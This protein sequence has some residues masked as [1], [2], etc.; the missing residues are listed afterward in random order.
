MNEFRG[1]PAASRKNKK[2]TQTGPLARIKQ[3]TTHPQPA[4]VTFPIGVAQNEPTDLQ[5]EADRLL[6]ATYVPAAVIVNEHLDI[7]Q[8]RGPAERYLELPPGKASRNLLRTVRPGLLFVLQKALG[9][10]RKVNTLML[11]EQASVESNGDLRHVNI[12]ITP[13]Q[14]A[15]QQNFL[16]VFHEQEA[17]STAEP[18][19]VPAAREI[20]RMKKQIEQ[21]RQELAIT[22]EYLQSLV[23][24]REAASEELQSANEEIQSSNEELQSTNEELQTSKEELKAAN[25][26]LNTVTEEMQRR[27]QQITNDLTNL[28]NSVNIPIVMLGSDLSV[29]RFTLQAEKVLGLS[30]IDVGH[31]VAKVKMK[32]PIPDLE[33]SVL[34][35]IRT[36]T[37]KQQK[38]HTPNSEW[39]SLQ[40]TPCR[41]SDNKIEGAVLVL[42][43][44]AS[45]SEER[46][47]SAQKS[48][49]R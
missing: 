8:T 47:L 17:G 3:P 1:K 35:V 20:D 7:L 11:R 13:I 21:L 34:D 42:F 24:E 4:L 28:L 32:F 43:E 45:Q 9:A 36:L 12:E 33:Q 5:R 18:K 29:R 10:A 30:A 27:N 46:A 41:T 25:E 37:P 14:V 49:R 40:I 39:Y 16:I 19:A 31:P 48:T 44:E 15:A 38:F 2:T 6:L 22:R 26:E 23:G